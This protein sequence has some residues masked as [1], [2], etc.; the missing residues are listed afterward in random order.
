MGETVVTTPG[1]IVVHI[2]NATEGVY[3]VTQGVLKILVSHNKL[4]THKSFKRY[5]T[6]S[7]QSSDL[8]SIKQR[9]QEFGILMAQQVKKRAT[10][11]IRF[12]Q[13]KTQLSDSGEEY[14]DIFSD[15][16]F[17][18][19]KGDYFGE[20]SL[21]RPDEN[22]QKSIISLTFCDMQLLRKEAFQAAL[23]RFPEVQFN[24]GTDDQDTDGPDERREN[25]R[26]ALQG[27]IL[28]KES[29]SAS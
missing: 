9:V 17:E 7:H 14:D 27:E 4:K 20:E 29:F 2:G 13:I 19:V 26:E 3:F 22:A 6:I 28:Y 10:N 25:V 18:I 16:K 15:D 23:K 21:E 5:Q 1:D 11:Y 8:E 12:Q 24:A